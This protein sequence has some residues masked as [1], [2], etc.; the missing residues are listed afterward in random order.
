M[1]GR[2]IKENPWMLHEI[3]NELYGNNSELDKKEILLKYCD[4]VGAELER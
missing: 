4:F 3:E 1:I 2:E